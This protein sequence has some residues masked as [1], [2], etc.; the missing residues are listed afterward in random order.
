[1]RSA[2]ERYEQVGQ[3]VERKG[4]A[5]VVNGVDVRSEWGFE[6]LEQAHI[7]QNSFC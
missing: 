4:K 7:Y 1:M 2:V 3:S 5:D 6:N